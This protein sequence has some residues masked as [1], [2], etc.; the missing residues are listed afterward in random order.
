MTQKETP[1]YLI[2]GEVLRPHGIRGELRVRLLTDYPERITKLNKIYLGVGPESR[3]ISQHEVE[4]MRMNK[5]YG[6]L[7]LKGIKDRSQ[8]DV[9]R[10]LYVMVGIEDAVPLEDDEIYLFQLIGMRVELEDG[11]E[12]G[13]VKDVIETGANDV[14]I[15][16]SP[17]HGEVLIPITPETLLET[18]DENTFMRVKLP[19]GLLPDA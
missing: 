9:L 7:K 11:S 4:Q 6:L 5:D 19:D 13:I 18:D 17:Q 14:Y 10:D 8:A 1:K 15:V 16:D 2:V 12:L 3:K